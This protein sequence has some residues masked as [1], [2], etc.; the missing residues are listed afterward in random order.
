M[1]N[2]YWILCGDHIKKYINVKSLCST[3]ETKIILY[4]N[5]IFLKR[6]P[7]IKCIKEFV[8]E[9]IPESEPLEVKKIR[10]KKYAPLFL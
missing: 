4:A 10:E 8:H 7:W 5:Y 3:P 2:D 9:A 6:L 1:T